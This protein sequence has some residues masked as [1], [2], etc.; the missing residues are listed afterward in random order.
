[1]KRGDI[2]IAGSSIFDSSSELLVKFHHSSWFLC[3]S[4][5]CLSIYSIWENEERYV[6]ATAKEQDD[7]TVEAC[8]WLYDESVPARGSIA[9]AIST[10]V[11]V[12]AD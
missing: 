6:G 4:I 10:T 9:R 3:L 8:C 5:Y 11:L 7:R 12:F 1:M 2:I